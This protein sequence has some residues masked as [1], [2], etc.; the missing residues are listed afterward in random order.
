MC[1]PQGTFPN[2]LESMF[3]SIV[4]TENS[5]M[6]KE[7]FN[8]TYTTERAIP[9]PPRRCKVAKSRCDQCLDQPGCKVQEGRPSLLTTVSCLS[10]NHFPTL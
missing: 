2:A 1:G 10:H 4:C 5:V 6:L 9:F 8:Q 7:L 3:N